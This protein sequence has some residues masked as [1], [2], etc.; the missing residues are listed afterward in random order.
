M[1]GAAKRPVEEKELVMMAYF[2]DKCYHTPLVTVDNGFIADVASV[3]VSKFKADFSPNGPFWDQAAQ[4]YYN[5]HSQH[6]HGVSPRF[7]KEPVHGFP[8]LIAQL[9]KDLPQH[10]FPQGIMSNSPF[11]PA[12]TDL[13]K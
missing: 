12:T 1:V 7:N 3:C 4:S 13:F 11:Q 2:F 9:N 6:V 8:F 10:N 5:W